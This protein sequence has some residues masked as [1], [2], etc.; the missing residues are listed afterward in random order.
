M[1][2]F[3]NI[4][5][6]VFS[7]ILPYP[8]RL[9]GRSTLDRKGCFFYLEILHRCLAGIGYL[10]ATLSP[11]DEECDFNRYRLCACCALLFVSTR[12]ENV[13]TVV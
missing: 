2:S 4:P 7:R 6:K 1:H 3:P 12:L 8:H 10:L 9:V 13:F 11:G 5:L